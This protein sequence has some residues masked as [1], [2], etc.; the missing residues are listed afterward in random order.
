MILNEKLFKEFN[1]EFDADGDWFYTYQALKNVGSVQDYSEEFEFEDEAI[2]FAKDHDYD[3]VVRYYY[4]IIDNSE[5][6]WDFIDYVN[7]GH[8]KYNEEIWNRADKL[9]EDFKYSDEDEVE[10][11]GYIIAPFTINDL[12]V[13]NKSLGGFT[14]YFIKKGDAY[15]KDKDFTSVEDAKKFIDSATKVKESIDYTDEN[16]LYKPYWYLTKH[17]I[18]PGSVPKRIS[19]W[20]WF[21]TPEGT[22]FASSNVI[23]TQELEEYEIVEKQPNLEDIPEKSRIDIQNF[24]ETPLSYAD[25]LIEAKGLTKEIAVLQGNYGYGWDDLIEYELNDMSR[26]QDLKDYD[27]NE[28]GVPHRIIHRRVPRD[29]DE[30]IKKTK[31]GKWVNV[32]KEGT[33]GEFKTKKA[34]REQ[35]KAMFARGFKESK[36]L[37]ETGEWEDDEEGLLWKQQLLDLIHKYTTFDNVELEDVKG[38]DKYQ[39]PYVYDSGLEFWVDNEAENCLLIHNLNYNL[40]SDSGWYRIC[41]REDFEKFEQGNLEPLQE[42]LD[43]REDTSAKAFSKNLG[44]DDVQYFAKKNRFNYDVDQLRIDNINKTYEFG[45]FKILSSRES[46]KNSK[47]FE[48]LV[49]ILKDK[50]Y[51][52]VKNTKNESVEKQPKKESIKLTNAEKIYDKLQKDLNKLGYQIGLNRRTGDIQINQR[53]FKEN[54]RYKSGTITTKE[55]LKDAIDLANEYGL[56]TSVEVFLHKPIL[57]IHT[58]ELFNP[59]VTRE[60]LN[61]NLKV[62]YE[63]LYQTDSI[64]GNKM[65]FEVTDDGQFMVKDGEKV[66]LNTKVVDVQDTKNQ[67]KSMQDIEVL[68]EDLNKNLDDEVAK[69]VEMI[70]SSADE[71]FPSRMLSRL[72]SDFKYILGAVKDNAEK[73]NESVSLNTINKHLWFHDIDKQAALMKEIYER[74]DEK[75]EDLTLQD[76]DNFVTETKQLLNKKKAIEE[77]LER[78]IEDLNENP[79][80]EEEID[81]TAGLETVLNDLINDENEAINGYNSAIVN[82]EVEGRGDLTQVFRDIIKDEQN[83]IGNLQKVLNEINPDTLKNIQD[84]QKEAEETLQSDSNSETEETNE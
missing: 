73:N 53:V 12:K 8:P 32:G 82:F 75:P 5:E 23:S 81:P 35:Q 59:E 9:N 38:F 14:K 56:K 84:G 54:G 43:L 21:E 30:D 61:N 7:Y 16:Y 2:N 34:A 49:D 66:I 51:K 29:L 40:M 4:P 10:Y 19:I 27:E 83:H 44:K 31:S 60:A 37:V 74:L 63:S 50:G 64:S 69:E 77:D 55:A 46:T 62:K 24:L 25:S 79:G 78:E 33:H 22:Y 47:E 65:T 58:T 28:K 20:T 57:T 72:K 45:Q 6:T 18:G 52:E 70:F 68:Q 26:K 67:I 42:S 48:R 13:G 76:I 36:R 39:G 15:Y 1:E 41:S 17:G 80:D 3:R 11:K 71:T